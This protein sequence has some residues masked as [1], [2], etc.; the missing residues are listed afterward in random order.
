MKPT[1]VAGLFA[2][3]TLAASAAPVPNKPGAYWVSSQKNKVPLF[4]QPD[5]RSKAISWTLFRWK[6][7]VVE[8]K[9]GFGR[10]S[11]YMPGNEFGLPGQVAYWIPLSAL[12]TE[13][14]PAPTT[15]TNEPEFA[16]YIA[17]GDNFGKYRAAFIKGTAELVA[18][19]VCSVEDFKQQGGWM[20]D[21]TEKS[22]VVYFTYC[23]GMTSAN[24][25]FL[26]VRTGHGYK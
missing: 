11:S 4:S 9:N 19:H 23:G 8:T 13:R 12:D 21:P 25:V 22:G 14:P 26:N 17:D 5:A 7:N 18:S 2:A 24:R 16:K 20:L 6:A 3:A 10:V 15:S 1:F